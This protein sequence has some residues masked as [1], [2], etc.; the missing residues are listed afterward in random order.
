MLVCN[1]KSQIGLIIYLEQKHLEVLARQE[2]E[3]DG[4]D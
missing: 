4:L 2:Y 3:Y 1:Y